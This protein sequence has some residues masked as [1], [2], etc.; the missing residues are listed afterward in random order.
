MGN[1]LY[2]QK[3]THIKSTDIVKLNN[4]INSC[5]LTLRDSEC[6][7]NFLTQRPEKANYLIKVN[8]KENNI[9]VYNLF[10]DI[11]FLPTFGTNINDHISAQNITTYCAVQLTKEQLLIYNRIKNQYYH[12]RK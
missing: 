1:I 4:Y 11:M 9:L 7:K 8:I 12:N 6:W 3:V 2:K 5:N 10:P